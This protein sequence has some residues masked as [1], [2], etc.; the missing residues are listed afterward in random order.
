LSAGAHPFTVT[1]THTHTN[2]SNTKNTGKYMSRNDRK[3]TLLLK[4]SI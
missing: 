3:S 4:Y 2:T 1:Q